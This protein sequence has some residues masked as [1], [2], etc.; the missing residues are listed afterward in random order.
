MTYDFA[1]QRLEWEHIPVEE[2]GY[3][4][5]VAL[6]AASDTEILNLAARA[7]ASRY[8]SDRNPV[9]RWRRYL[10]ENVEGKHVFD[11]GCGF[12]LEALQLARR[13]ARLTLA[14][15]NG[16]SV[17]VARRVLALHGHAEQVVAATL[18][19]DQL[20]FFDSPAG[21]VDVFYACGVLHHLP[22]PREVLFQAS[23]LLS[24]GGE[25]RLMVYTDKAWTG[26]T[27]RQLPSV[28]ADVTA[29][30]GFETF[31]KSFD[32]VGKYADWY[33]EEKLGRRFGDFL[34]VTFYGELNLNG[35][36]AA[37]VMKPR[38]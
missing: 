24:P 21:P 31:Y 22:Y 27:N 25:I 37:A 35:V 5:G 3:P 34:D 6:L 16:T 30:P 29:D 26:T 11:F 20:P 9:G 7:E 38:G 17:A 1:A 14:D 19:T 10:H 32:C 2:A 13:G 12:G 36:Y 23:K 8:S 4:S 28:D 33:N 15:I 18:V